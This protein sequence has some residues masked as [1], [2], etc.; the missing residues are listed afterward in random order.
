MNPNIKITWANRLAFFLL[1]AVAIF[2]TVAYGAVHQPIIALVYVFTVII[3]ILW[4]F[5]AFFSG[6][7]RI[8]KSL[9]QIPLY[10][11]FLYGIIQIIPFG[12]FEVGGLSEIP[13]TLSIEP[14][15]TKLTAFHIL[16]LCFLFSAFLI[17]IDSAKRI[18]KI[19]MIITIFGF[20]YSFYAILQMVL[21]PNK[22]YGIYEAAYASPFGSFVNRHNFAAFMEMTIALPLGLVFVGAVQK[23]KRLLYF[24][25]IGIMGA[26]MLLSGSRG[27]LVAL[28]AEI[29]FLAL[30]TSTG[31]KR[32]GLWFKLAWSVLLIAAIIAGSIFIGGGGESS[33]TRFAETASS[34][35]ITTDRSHIW[36][37]TIEAIKER[38]ILGSGLGSFN[39]AYAKHDTY[40]GLGRVEQAHND[41]LQILADAGI[42][43]LI[44]GI[45]FLFQLFKT[46][47]ASIK[48]QNLYRRGIA[49][50][51]LAGC[52]AI[53][54]HSIFDFV[55]HTTAISIMFLILV[56][57][58]VR[59][60]DSFEDDQEERSE[61]HQRRQKS[62]A[63]S[64]TPI[65]R[66]NNL[67]LSD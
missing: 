37:V 54:V 49:V 45:F 15:W 1:I 51:A 25:A 56:S 16:A 22:I 52:F 28:L 57:L 62:R 66:P 58:V 48:T 12:T 4:G 40:N 21:S 11:L 55:L 13:R 39:A 23:D 36:S 30:L 18:R 5:D 53:L 10:C 3:L 46:G 24:T 61:R 41:Y 19:V 50:G 38:P 29:F 7:L 59:S 14:N 42:V 8:N 67:E 34:K 60:G 17:F 63:A 27:G 32:G 65:T 2:T 47:R 64:V 35:D 31:G 20:I 44:I 33:L 9:L 26:A 6:A 43:G